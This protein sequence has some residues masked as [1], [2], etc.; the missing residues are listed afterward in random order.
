M[1]VCRARFFLRGREARE[2][3]K[4]K[5]EKIRGRP[6]FSRWSTALGSATH[7]LL[8][9][10][11]TTSLAGRSPRNSIGSGSDFSIVGFTCFLSL[12]LK[13]GAALGLSLRAH[14]WKSVGDELGA[15]GKRKLF[16][17]W[18]YCASAFQIQE[19]L[20]LMPPGIR[21]S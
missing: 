15:G 3:K 13:Q 17:K 20:S 11:K 16:L 21:H 8:R 18:R 6:R 9:A 10:R 5:K 14:V 19:G 12:L 4:G 7:F 2:Q 1:P